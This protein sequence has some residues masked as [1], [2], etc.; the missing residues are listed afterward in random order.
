MT[1][2]EFLLQMLQAETTDILN[3]HLPAETVK[4]VFEII[5]EYN[6]CNSGNCNSGFFNTD[7]P[8]VHIFNKEIIILKAE[9]NTQICKD[10]CHQIKPFAFY[11]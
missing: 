5:N 6:S 11:L 10:P 1:N 9:Q 8:L 7:S 4:E 2:K 3:E